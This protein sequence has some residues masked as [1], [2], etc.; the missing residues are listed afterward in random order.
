MVRFAFCALLI[1]AFPPPGPSSFLGLP[2]AHPSAATQ[3]GIV[4]ASGGA[5]AARKTTSRTC[6]YTHHTDT[7]THTH[8]R[9]RAICVHSEPARQRRRRKSGAGGLPKHP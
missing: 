1:R 9:V 3:L 8:A 7:D 6:T 5:I 2:D 4:D